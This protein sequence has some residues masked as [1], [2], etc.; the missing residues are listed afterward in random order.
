MFLL[1]FLKLNKITKK[2]MNEMNDLFRVFTNPS[3]NY[4]V[5]VRYYC[6]N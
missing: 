3:L 6:F 2:S 5:T 4:T 1:F